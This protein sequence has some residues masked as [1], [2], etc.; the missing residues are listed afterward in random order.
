M[1]GAT[2]AAARSAE[3]AELKSWYRSKIQRQEQDEEYDPSDPKNITPATEEEVAAEDAR[4]LLKQIERL[5]VA[6]ARR[7]VIADLNGDAKARPILSHYSRVLEDFQQRAGGCA[8][9]LSEASRTQLQRQLRI[10]PRPSA[11]RVLA[12]KTVGCLAVVPVLVHFLCT[13]QES[14]GSRASSRTRCSS[15]ASAGSSWSSS[16]SETW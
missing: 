16:S 10:R 9:G 7:S 5:D 8:V 15:Q 14:W 13:F 2:A 1:P 12:D 4:L 3:I 11:S 6:L